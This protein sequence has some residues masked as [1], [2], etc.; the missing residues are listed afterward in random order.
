MRATM[1][2][3]TRTA[4]PPPPITADAPA[5]PQT[6]LALILPTP[7]ARLRPPATRHLQYAIVT[8]RDRDSASRAADMARRQLQLLFVCA[9]ALAAL[10]SSHSE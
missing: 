6:R 9:C 1:P 4:A 10:S 8:A 3:A 7:P 5:I 2:C